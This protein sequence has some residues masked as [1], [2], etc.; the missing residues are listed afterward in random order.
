MDKKLIF[1]DETENF[2]VPAEPKAGE[3][4]VLRLWAPREKE[5]SVSFI[6]R[7]DDVTRTLKAVKVG[8]RGCLDVYETLCP[9]T[10]SGL[11]YFV[12]LRSGS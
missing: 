6:F 9:G 12:S 3:P 10:K 4:F 5:L 8:E 1:C 2:R 7:E 11:L